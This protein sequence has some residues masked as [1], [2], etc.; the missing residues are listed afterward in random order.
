MIDL[1]NYLHLMLLSAIFFGVVEQSGRSILKFY[2]LKYLESLE[3]VYERS[4]VAKVTS[5]VHALLVTLFAL[6]IIITVHP[7]TLKQMEESTLPLYKKICAFTGGY[8][9]FDIYG[10]GR[11]AFTHFKADLIH[12]LVSFCIALKGVCTNEFEHIM[13]YGPWMLTIEITTVFMNVIVIITGLRNKPR[14]E[15]DFSQ[16]TN[17]LILVMK[18]VFAFTFLLFRVF[19]FPVIIGHMHYT[20]PKQFTTYMNGALCMFC[21]VL[22]LLQWFWFY[23]I[24]RIATKAL[25][26]HRSSEL[27]NKSK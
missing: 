1:E 3:D 11:Y 23:K 19:L 18:M 4:Y 27:Y 10:M 26:K 8:F 21:Y 16:M 20:W 2:V 15:K 7:Y 6:Y 14:S 12:H 24:F 13:Y 17:T 9:I 25:K 22:V 5:S